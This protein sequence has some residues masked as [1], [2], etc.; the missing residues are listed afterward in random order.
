[1]SADSESEV[2]GPVAMIQRGVA[3]LGQLDDFLAP[4]L[5]VL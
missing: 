1:M 2:S 4:H 3:G 5:D